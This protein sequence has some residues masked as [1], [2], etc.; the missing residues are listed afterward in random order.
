MTIPPTT[1]PRKTINIGSMS[2]VS[3]ETVALALD[4][5]EFGDLVHHAVDVARRLTRLDHVFHHRREKCVGGE[6]FRNLAALA[7]VPGDFIARVL[8]LGLAA[9]RGD[10]LE[11][12]QDRHARA[13]QGRVGAAEAGERDLVNQAAE[14]GGLDEE[15]ILRRRPFGVAMNFIR[16]NQRP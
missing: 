14:D 8:D 12:P 3:A 1:T 9:R 7:D 6:N 16:S 4:V 2:E 13:D 15:F 5:V 10:D 11:R